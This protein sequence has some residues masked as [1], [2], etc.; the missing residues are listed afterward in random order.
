MDNHQAV[1]LL[2]GERARVEE[3][4]NVATEVGLDD[5]AGASEQ[6]DMSDPAESLVAEQEEDAI[7]RGLRERLGAI[8]RAEQRLKDGVYGLS[9][10]SGLPIPAERLEADPAAEL[11][12]E[13]AAEI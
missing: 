8:E 6:G 2:R 13:E 12:V 11:T 4:L 5:R 1:E 9:T 3:L 10:R 7:A